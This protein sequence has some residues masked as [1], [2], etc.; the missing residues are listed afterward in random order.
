MYYLHAPQ[1]LGDPQLRHRNAQI[2][3]ATSHDLT[4][5]TDL[6]MV[7]QPGDPGEFDETATWTGSVIQGTDGIWRMFYTG[8]RFLSDSSNVNVESIGV[9]QSADLHTWVKSRGPIAKADARWYETLG[10]SSW[11]E[12]AW[13]DPWVFPDPDGQGWH[14]LLT[15]RSN[16]GP[17][18][19]RGVIGHAT[20]ADLETWHVQPPLSSP[21]A[22]FAHLEVPQLTTVDNR[23]LLLFSCDT[24]AL[25]DA[26]KAHG[27]RG[28]VWALEPAS[29][30]G[31]Y[32]IDKAEL[33]APEALYSGRVIQNRSGEWVLLAF[34]NNSAGGE[35]IGRVSDPIVIAWPSDDSLVQIASQADVA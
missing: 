1:S 22:G 33:F 10:T 8:S 17:D 28:G 6:G 20:S 3:H 11:P 23:R 4:T 14:M 29:T 34:E 31:P 16:S 32:E 21:G 35:F 24:G 13:R 2:G 12:E 15:A 9:A 26:R 19:E 27:E 7:L 5:W 30:L 18:D 25:S